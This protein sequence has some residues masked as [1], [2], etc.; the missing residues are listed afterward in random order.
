MDGACLITLGCFSSSRSMICWNHLVAAQL[1][2]PCQSS[3][4]AWESMCRQHLMEWN[5]TTQSCICY[6]G[7][8]PDDQDPKMHSQTNVPRRP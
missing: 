1:N 6:D 8:K 4:R 7:N 5:C 2:S 3:I